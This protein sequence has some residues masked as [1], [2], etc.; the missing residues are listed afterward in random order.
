MV[1]RSELTARGKKLVAEKLTAAGIVTE[2]PAP[3]KATVEELVQGAYE[4]KL[5]PNELGQLEEA[6]DQIEGHAISE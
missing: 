6:L 2:E 3:T 1:Y 5:N 4:G